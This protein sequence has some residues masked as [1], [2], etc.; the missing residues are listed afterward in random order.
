[1]GGITIFEDISILEPKCPGCQG[2]I[3]L[4]VTTR[5]NIRKKA[6]VCLSC[7]AVLR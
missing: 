1:M 6:H 2:I 4:G 3:K 7:G 5:Y